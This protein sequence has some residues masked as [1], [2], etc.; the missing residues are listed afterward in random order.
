M[1]ST[2]E[3]IMLLDVQAKS[4]TDDPAMKLQAFQGDDTD[5]PPNANDNFSGNEELRVLPGSPQ[6]LILA[7]KIT[8]SKLAVG[9]GSLVFPIPAGATPTAVSVKQTRIEATL[10]TT[11]QSA[12][13]NG[14]IT[15]VIPWS[16]V[17]GKLI[18]TIAEG[19]DATYKSSTTP[20]ATKDII[21]TLFDTNGDSAISADEIR[22][23]PLLGLLLAPD[24]D[25]NAD[26]KIDAQD[27]MSIGIGFT[28]VTCTI[29]K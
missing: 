27:S 21:K 15:G 7:G 19:V 22:K 1:L 4:A 20:Q 28:G 18:P 13:Q 2:G 11:P 24:V 23:S 25:T 26:G 17:D 16:E 14:V 12:M 8:A 29:K 6:D 10:G 3:F 5:T 9:P